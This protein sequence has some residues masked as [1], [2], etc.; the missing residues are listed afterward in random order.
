MDINDIKMLECE[1]ENNFP[2]DK[3]EEI[4]REKIK[5]AI[6]SGDD[7]FFI[8]EYEYDEYKMLS[9]VIDFP[10][11]HT[12]GK[13]YFRNLPK[14]KFKIKIPPVI[15]VVIGLSCICFVFLLVNVKLAFL[16]IVIIYSVVAHCGM[17]EEMNE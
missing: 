14:E 17:D 9:K 7:Y 16:L 8:E 3:Y 12:W 1:V 2:H 6:K 10:H 5:D 13:V 4:L 11:I 15:Q